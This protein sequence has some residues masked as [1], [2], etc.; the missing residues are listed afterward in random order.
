M[1][2][3]R[4]VYLADTATVRGEV[5]IGRD[6]NIWYGAVV[7]GDVAPISI[8]SRTNVQDGAVLHCDDDQPLSVGDRVTIGHGA[9]VHCSVV[10]DDVLIGMGATVLGGVRIGKGAVIAAGAVVAP[11]SEIP[12][13]MVAMGVPAKVKR[14]VSEEER[15]F[16]QHNSD[17]YVDMARR[18]AS[19]PNDPRTRPY[20]Q[21]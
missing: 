11:G 19:N 16:T 7:R 17:H 8:G 20:G 4:G 18:Q 12:E 10:E 13:G 2:V 14:P 6:T 9:I 15:A 3:V 21:R 5:T 1:R